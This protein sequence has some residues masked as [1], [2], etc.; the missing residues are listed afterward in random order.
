VVL[1]LDSPMTVHSIK[2][3]VSVSVMSIGVN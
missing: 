2:L 1:R 3:V